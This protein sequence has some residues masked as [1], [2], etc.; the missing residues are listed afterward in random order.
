[1]RLEVSSSHRRYS[2]QADVLAEGRVGITVVVCS[3]DG[4]IH[5][6]LTGEID[7]CDVNE[8][9]RLIVSAPVVSAVETAPSTTFPA[10]IKATRP[11]Q[12]W[13]SEAVA[14]LEEHYRAGKGPGQLAEELGRS[15]KSIRWKLYGLKLAPYPSDLVPAPRPAA[16]PEVSKAYTVEDKRRLHPNAYKSWSPE[17]EQ[18]LA[19]R[20]AQG[21]SLSELSQ[22]FGRNEGAIASRLL[23][24]QAEG[25]AADEAWEYGG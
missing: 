20:C 3:P 5:G 19:K 1:M 12:A 9:G 2:L 8:V 16:E 6:E 23:K 24:I 13:T 4:V 11:G 22:E 25:L 7:V 15:E 10:A 17:D 18:R 14:Y 21:V